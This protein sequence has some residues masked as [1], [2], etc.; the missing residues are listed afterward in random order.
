LT[1]MIQN[2]PKSIVSQQYRYCYATK[3]PPKLR[4]DIKFFIRDVQSRARYVISSLTTRVMKM[5]FFRALVDYLKLEMEPHSQ[6]YT[7]SWIK[8]PLY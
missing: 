6:P 5:S 4:S 8:K 3:P 1:P 2:L 7:I